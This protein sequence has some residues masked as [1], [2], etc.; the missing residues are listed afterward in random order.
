MITVAW[1]EA[2][3]SLENIIVVF[4]MR[5]TPQFMSASWPG[6][7][8]TTIYDTTL[9]ERSG[10]FYLVPINPQRKIR[11]ESRC[12]EYVSNYI[13]SILQTNPPVVR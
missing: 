2:F 10:S 13:I 5:N 7:T 12:L 11:N 4:I 3:S 8:P 9:E 1:E 6:F